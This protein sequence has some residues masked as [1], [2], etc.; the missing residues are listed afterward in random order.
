[1]DRFIDPLLNVPGTY[2]AAMFPERFTN[3]LEDDRIYL[4]VRYIRIWEIFF[5]TKC[6]KGILV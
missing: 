6:L 2:P 5:V 3:N 4:N 1:M